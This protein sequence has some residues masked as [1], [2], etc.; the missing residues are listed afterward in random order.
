MKFQLCVVL[1][2]RV[3]VR[4][5]FQIVELPKLYV[6]S[7]FRNLFCPYLFSVY[8]LNVCCCLQLFIFINYQRTRGRSIAVLLEY[9]GNQLPLQ[10]LNPRVKKTRLK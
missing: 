10:D 9:N 2:S 5:R 1:F 4:T 8:D 6:S 3:K 7:H